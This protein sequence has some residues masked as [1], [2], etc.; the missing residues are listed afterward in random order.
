MDKLDMLDRGS[1]VEQVINLIENISDNQVSTCFAINGT[2]GTGKSFVLDMIEEQLETIQSPET[3]RE[4][5]FIVRYNC[6]KYD[7]YEEPLIAIVSAIISEIEEKTK[8]FPDSQAKQEI[9]GMFRAAGVSLLS[10]ANTAFKAKTGLDIQSAYETVIKGEKEGAEKYEKD[11][12]YD[13]YLGLNKVIGKLSN[14]IQEIAND[15]TVVIIVDELDR[16]I[17]EY[18]IKVLERLHHL[19]EEQRNIITIIAIDKSQLLASVKQLFGFDNPEKYLEKFISFEIKLDKGSVSEMITEKYADYIEMF[20]RNIFQFE[21]SVEECLQAI[22]KNID[23]RTQEQIVNKVT[24][25]H[26]LLYKEK[27]DYSFMCMELILAVMIIVYDDGAGFLKKSIDMHNLE[28]VFSSSKR[29]SNP[30]FSTFFKEK[31]EQISFTT[32]RNFEDEPRS[33]LLPAKGNLYGA[34]IFTWYWMHE[35]NKNTIIQHVEGDSYD[36]I[37]RNYEDLKKFVETLDMM[38]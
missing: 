35:K 13:T 11:H 29:Q 37:S 5:Y 3:V 36:V 19:T 30:V 9:L 8:M 31:F 27:K 28:N 26:K 20:D 10:I 4:K 32:R 14:L 15:Y 2:W 38:R 21:D 7:Y 16:C 17:P 6:W 33:Y 23:V 22:F 1:F 18:A 12:E 24:V 34:I 25:A